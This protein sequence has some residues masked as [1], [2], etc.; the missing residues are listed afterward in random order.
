MA[1]RYWV[2]VTEDLLADELTLPEGLRMIRHGDDASAIYP[3]SRWCYFEDDSAP[4]ELEGKNIQLWFERVDDYSAR[5][6]E[7]QVMA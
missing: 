2:L 7:R 1:A 5:I 3:G 6:L 4:P